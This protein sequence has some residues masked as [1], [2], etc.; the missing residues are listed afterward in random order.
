MADH[1]YGLNVGDRFGSNVA[2][3]TVTTLKNLEVR[4]RDATTG[5]S[6]DEAYNL[7]EVIRDYIITHD[8]PA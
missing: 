4:I 2:F 6:K 1:F 8:A 5:M 3:S 7:I